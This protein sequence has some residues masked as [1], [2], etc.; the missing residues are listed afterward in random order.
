MA[1]NGLVAGALATTA[2]LGVDAA[3]GPALADPRPRLTS[4]LTGGGNGSLGNGSLGERGPGRVA[5]D[6]NNSLGAPPTTPGTPVPV[7]TDYLVGARASF[8]ENLARLAGVV[9]GDLKTKIED[10]QKTPVAEWIGGDGIPRLRELMS[11]GAS[12]KK[13]P[14]VV[15]YHIPNRD[16][17]NHSGGGAA[18]A[19]AYRTWIDQVSNTVG[20]GKAVV[21]V[22][23][24][25]LAHMVA[26]EP[27]REPSSAQVTERAQLLADVLKK[28]KSSNPNASVYLDAGTAGWPTVAQTV[29][30]LNRVKQAGADIS[31]ISLNVSN[32]KTDDETQQ[33][34]TAVGT[35]FGKPLSLMID[36]SRNGAPVTAAGSESWCNPRGQRLGTP[37]SKTF[38]AAAPVNKLYIKTPGE[39]DGDCGA[40]PNIGA[41]TFA[42]EI[43]F[44]QLGDVRHQLDA[45]ARPAAS[46]P[47]ARTSRPASRTSRP[48]A[49]RTSRPAAS[50]SRAAVHD[51]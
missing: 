29:D 44:M 50:T 16:L 30:G 15:L 17:G 12:Q 10:L 26:P 20:T 18:N 21:I 23:P 35:A 45:T 38:T 48:A 5:E 32:F 11:Q 19:A 42:D 8:Y 41:G 25:A 2:L 37:A 34:G 28:F 43:L 4:P 51:R 31:A 36:N 22:E 9:S 3:A 7:P 46:R 14:V 47:A 40:F 1:K 49:A 6:G 24:D 13:V 27:G 33:H 39:S